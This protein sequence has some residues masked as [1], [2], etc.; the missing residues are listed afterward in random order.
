M[1][2]SHQLALFLAAAFLLSIAPGPGMLYVLARTLHGGRKE[3]MASILGT[4]VGG[5]VHVLAA[6]LGLSAILLGSA[7]A[8]GILKYAGAAYLV[9]LGVRMIL[10]SRQPL[11]LRTA[12]SG[13]AHAT[14]RQGV[15]TEALNPKTAIF[16][17]T[18]LPQFVSP[19][20]NATLQFLL[21]GGISV[22]LNSTADVVVALLA[23]P[24]ARG[25]DRNPRW[26]QAQQAGCGAGLIGL[27]AYVAVGER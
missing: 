16:F 17:F 25:M 2:D 23:A 22:A 13:G 15:L 12:E 7:V 6:A 9:Y 1:I 4:A 14:F 19:G 11:E 3:A 27:G 10:T 20:G 8:Y 26:R 24:L 5:L 18:F 21:L